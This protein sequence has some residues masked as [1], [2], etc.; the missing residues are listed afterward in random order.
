[1]KTFTITF[2]VEEVVE[3]LKQGGKEYGWVLKKDLDLEQLQ[4]VF[5]ED[6]KMTIQLD[7]FF[8]EGINQDVYNDFFEEKEWIEVEEFDED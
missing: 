1:M 6:L 8:V 5:S 3:A 7:E 2:Q 4:E